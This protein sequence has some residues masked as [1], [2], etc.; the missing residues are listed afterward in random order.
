[1]VLACFSTFGGGG[2][3]MRTMNRWIAVAGIM[4]V[5]AACGGTAAPPKQTSSTGAS[6][7]PKVSP[8]FQVPNPFKI[9]ARFSASSLGLKQVLSLDVGPDGN[10]YVTD[11]SQQVVVISSRG[12]VL[13]RWGK[14]GS[15]PGE[16]RFAAVST[17][18]IIGNLAVGPDG[19]VYVSDSG[20][21]RIQIFSALGKFER[22]IGSFGE[23][24]GQFIAPTDLAVDDAGNLYVADDQLS[25][26][27]KFS[28]DGKFVWRIG[29]PGTNLEEPH[30][31]DVDI[32]GRL[33]MVSGVAGGV[34]YI[35]GNGHQVDF[36]PAR[37][38]C[39]VSVDDLGYTYM[40]GDPVGCKSG[41]TQVYDRTHR[42]V[43][44]WSGP[45][46]S[47]DSPLRFGPNGEVFAFDSDRSIIG[48]KVA[49]P[50]R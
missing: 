16:F 13:R 31:G 26:V 24:E 11:L 47:I 36:F 45:D 19:R 43:G 18:D 35:D 42:L 33:V 5:A 32:H 34:L 50:G 25:T 41:L 9:V 8:T 14:P 49:L 7:A 20:N 15:G 28:P 39:Q 23:G 3:T 38:G 30:P 2:G 27:S 48:L 12:K 1:M 40:N 37:V 44:E 22:Q 10:V 21:H 4:L 29:G 6:A 17:S 46:D